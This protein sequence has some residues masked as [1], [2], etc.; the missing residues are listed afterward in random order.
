MKVDTVMSNNDED[1][2]EAEI[3]S[4]LKNLILEDGCDFD[5]ESSDD[6]DPYVPVME[7]IEVFVQVLF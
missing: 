7:N 3:E 5:D 6:I 4:Q 2:I 1:L